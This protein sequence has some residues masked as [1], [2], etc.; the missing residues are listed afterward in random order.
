[1]NLFTKQKQTHLENKIML[2]QRERLKLGVLD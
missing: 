1:M 2:G